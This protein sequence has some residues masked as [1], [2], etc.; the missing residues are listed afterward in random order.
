VSNFLDS[1]LRGVSPPLRLGCLGFLIAAV[2]A[3][4]GFSID[5]KPGNPLAYVAFF[6]VAAGVVLGFVSVSWG[7]VYA[8]QSASKRARARAYTKPM[9]I[10]KDP[11]VPPSGA[12]GL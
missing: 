9:P 2:G 8:I 6:T 12:G 11:N 5:Y 10:P 7:W 4:F 1:F 3:A